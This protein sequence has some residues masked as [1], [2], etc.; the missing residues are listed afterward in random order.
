MCHTSSRTSDTSLLMISQPLYCGDIMVYHD[1]STSTYGGNVGG[2][3][4]SFYMGAYSYSW[5][6]SNFRSSS[7]CGSTTA[8]VVSV[9]VPRRRTLQRT[10]VRRS[11]GERSS[12]VHAFASKPAGKSCCTHSLRP[13]KAGAHSADAPLL[14]PDVSVF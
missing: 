8:S 10:S 6:S 9:S 2:G 14:G 1:K 3:S 5:I 13:L 12:S 11:K 4:F 7:K